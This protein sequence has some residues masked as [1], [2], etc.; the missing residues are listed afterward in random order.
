MEKESKG[1]FQKKKGVRKDFVICLCLF[2]CN[3]LNSDELD[4]TN[5]LTKNTF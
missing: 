2:I 3:S 5:Y 4:V 1:F